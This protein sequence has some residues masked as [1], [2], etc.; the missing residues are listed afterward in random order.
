MAQE[1]MKRRA[2]NPDASWNNIYALMQDVCFNGDGAAEYQYEQCMALP[3][4][5]L[6][7]NKDPEEYCQCVAEKWRT[8]YGGY[9]GRMTGKVRNGI[10]VKARI[11]CQ[12]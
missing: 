12:R 11:H 5:Q 2:T 7:Q 6:P 10:Q 8:E 4:N 9:K 1:F 3:P